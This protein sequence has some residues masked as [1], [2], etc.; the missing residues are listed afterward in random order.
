MDRHTFDPVS[1]VFGIVFVIAGII[2]IAGGEITD[3][4]RFLL[5]L[6]LIGLGVA[7]IGQ[8]GS[9]VRGR[10]HTAND[11]PGWSVSA[12]EDG[13]GDEVGAEGSEYR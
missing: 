11:E 4:G 8:A 13:T 2:C 3:E 7:V 1:L 9:R 12:G 10:A 6:G 5:P